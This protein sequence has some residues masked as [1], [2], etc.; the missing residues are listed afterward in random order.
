[1]GPLDRYI[2]DA[3]EWMRH[4]HSRS[5]VNFFALYGPTPQFRFS[6]ISCAP[7]DAVLKRIVLEERENG[8]AVRV[9]QEIR[10][11]DAP[12]LLKLSRYTWNPRLR[13]LA[14]NKLEHITDAPPVSHEKRY[15]P[16]IKEGVS[17]AG[18]LA[19]CNAEKRRY[20]ANSDGLIDCLLYAEADEQKLLYDFA[21]GGKFAPKY[22]DGTEAS[23]D[24]EHRVLAVCNPNLTDPA[25]LKHLTLLGGPVGLAAYARGADRLDANEILLLTEDGGIALAAVERADDQQVLRAFADDTA[26]PY[27]ARMKA[28]GKLG[29]RENLRRY[30]SR[31]TRYHEATWRCGYDMDSSNYAAICACNDEATLESLYGAGDFHLVQHWAVRIAS[32]EEDRRSFTPP[33]RGRVPEES[34]GGIPAEDLARCEAVCR[35]LDSKEITSALS[36]M[37]PRRDMLFVCAVEGMAFCRG[38]AA[39][40]LGSL[41]EARE[42]LGYIAF[43]EDNPHVVR[44]AIDGICESDVLLRIGLDEDTRRKA[45]FR[46]DQLKHA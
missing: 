40:M 11:H 7:D 34:R 46:L 25:L 43:N 21:R 5:V 12:T 16:P 36:A 24:E 9:F 33:K 13:Q 42:E 27:A 23:P 17:F 6:A 22:Y 32:A 28:Y 38:R 15:I 18:Y 41:P 3:R 31:P 30:A 39:R 10:R 35:S 4:I 44:R 26:K 29:D 1:M 2:H 45:L 8:A 37:A 20:D 19:K 14:L